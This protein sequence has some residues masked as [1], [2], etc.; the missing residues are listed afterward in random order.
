MLKESKFLI[1]NSSA[2]IKESEVYAIPTINIGT[3]QKN[4][5]KSKNIINVDSSKNQIL[6][7][8]T[9]IENKKIEKSNYFGDGK[10]S[11]R[12]FEII[13]NPTIWKTSI[14]KQFID[15]I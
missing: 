5:T 6:N 15:L 9:Q 10:S 3:R 1:G 14:Q 8:I 4:R 13:I 12:F 7:A 2:G 11:Q